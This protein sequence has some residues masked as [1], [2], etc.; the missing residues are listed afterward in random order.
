MQ[1][2]AFM[3]TGNALHDILFPPAS[4]PTPSSFAKATARHRA[5]LAAEP[6]NVV[7]VQVIDDSTGEMAG[8]AKWCFYDRDAGR[9][10]RV[11]VD[12]V[13]PEEQSFAQRVM[14]EF[15]GAVLYPRK[16]LGVLLIQ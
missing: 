12:W 4:S 11:E 2:A 13:G 16:S 6:D 7:F 14:D 9:Q 1:Y 10:E 15:H 8:G 3:G 5:A